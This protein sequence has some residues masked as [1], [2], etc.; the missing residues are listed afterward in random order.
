MDQVPA[1]G[2]GTIRQSKDLQNVP[3]PPLD[4]WMRLWW[5]I[6]NS[7]DIRRSFLTF[8]S[9][10]PCM[11]TFSRASSFAS[12]AAGRLKHRPVRLLTSPPA[13]G[14]NGNR[15][16]RWWQV[17]SKGLRR[18]KVA[19]VLS[20]QYCSAYTHRAFWYGDR[21]RAAVGWRADE[22]DAELDAP[23]PPPASAWPDPGRGHFPGGR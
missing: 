23:L 19:Q 14:H 17:A 3:Q 9:R 21:P 18:R 10:Q 13:A 5:H 16:I 2:T 22:V 12:P 15:T 4:F 6:N 20:T 11:R 7:A 1:S 8:A